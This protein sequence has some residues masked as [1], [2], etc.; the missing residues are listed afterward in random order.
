M[1]LL[2]LHSPADRLLS[3]PVTNEVEPVLSAAVTDYPL[4]HLLMIV[5]FSPVISLYTA[6]KKMISGGLPPIVPNH[7]LL[8]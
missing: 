4:S 2:R 3:R 5:H 6:I 1:S 8:P 7:R